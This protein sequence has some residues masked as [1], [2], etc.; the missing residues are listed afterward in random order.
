MP[1]QDLHGLLLVGLGKRGVARYVGEHY[2]SD[3]A[4]V[5]R[6]LVL[7][8]KVSLVIKSFVGYAQ[9]YLL[10]LSRHAILYRPD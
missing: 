4:L 7:S 10:V 8:R 3:S 6:Q 5:L 2:R 1:V 9:L